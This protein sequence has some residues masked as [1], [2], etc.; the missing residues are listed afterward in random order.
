MSVILFAVFLIN[1][2]NYGIYNYATSLYVK[3][4]FAL[5]NHQ[6]DSIQLIAQFC[7]HDLSFSS[8]GKVKSLW[9]IQYMIHREGSPTC[10]ASCN[11]QRRPIV[12]QGHSILKCRAKL[13]G[14]IVSQF[15]TH[16]TE[17][18]STARCTAV[19]VSIADV[20]H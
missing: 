10:T 7:M 2:I 19:R 15:E 5:C 12:M 6:W 11:T 8:I 20:A 16:F 1:L 4:N 14:R 13:K 18:S 3:I 9:T 17:T